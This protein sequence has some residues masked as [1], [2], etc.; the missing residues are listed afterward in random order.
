MVPGVHLVPGGRWSR[1][2]LIA[3]ETLTLVDSGL[4]WSHRR[5]LR[6][7]SSLGRRPEEIGTILTTH[8]HP[9]HATGAL[10]ISKRTGARIMAHALDT[11]THRNGEVSLSYMGAFTSLNLPLPFLQRATVG[12]LVEDGELL[13]EHGGIR[14]IHSPGHTRGSVCYLLEDRGVLFTGD[15][16]FSDGRRLSRSVPFP[17]YDGHQY[18]RTLA[19]LSE[20]EFAT[21]CGGHG[22]PLVGDASAKLR[23]LLR[24][25]PELPTWGGFLTS[26]PRAG[27]I[28]PRTS[29]ERTTESR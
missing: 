11:K 10:S 15:T 21:V 5:V 27:C 22:A 28:R 16:L 8:S 26:L 18:R 17:G 6:Y 4:P 19:R 3:D 23:K 25:Y 2:Y 24:E 9:D 14:V 29:A 12:A 1:I 20:M 13:P 7:V